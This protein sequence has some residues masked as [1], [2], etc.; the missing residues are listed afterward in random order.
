MPVGG[1]HPA[2]DP[3]FAGASLGDYDVPRSCAPV[4]GGASNG[5]SLRC[6][7]PVEVDVV[8]Q[9][10]RRE[11][12]LMGAVMRLKAVLLDVIS[13]QQAQQLSDVTAAGT[14][15]PTMSAPSPP[16]HLV[17]P[18]HRSNGDVPRMQFLPAQQAPALPEVSYASTSIEEIQARH[19]RIRKE[20][21]DLQQPAKVPDAQPCDSLGAGKAGPFHAELE[22]RHSLRR[23]VRARPCFES[24][25]QPCFEHCN[26]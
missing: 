4:Q 15:G 22:K 1:S 9:A 8:L 17:A 18:W 21:D 5:R 20:L 7:V 12:V 19:S 26:Y 2:I 23:T 25:C 3:L 6:F 24:V 11:V 14:L 16:L 10:R 13:S